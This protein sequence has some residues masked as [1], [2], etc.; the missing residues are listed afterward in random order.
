MCKSRFELEFED[1]LRMFTSEV[2]RVLLAAIE[3]TEKEIE[4]LDCWRDVKKMG[5][6]IPE[7]PA[8]G[9]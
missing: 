8:S 9:C 2:E 3:E 5:R 7:D 6:F 4:D 1:M